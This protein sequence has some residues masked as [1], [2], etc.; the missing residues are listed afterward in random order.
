[1]RLQGKGWHRVFKST[2]TGKG[3]LALARTA[4]AHDLGLGIHKLNFGNLGGVFE[5][6]FLGQAMPFRFKLGL[7]HGDLHADLLWIIDQG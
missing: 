7:E 3:H 4:R 6:Q 5:G 2:A 1:M